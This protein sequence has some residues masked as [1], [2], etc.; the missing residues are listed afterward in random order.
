MC[1][2]R[3]YSKP[4]SYDVEIFYTAYDLEVEFEK[5]KVRSFLE[6]KVVQDGGGQKDIVD[7][8]N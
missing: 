2:S 4:S 8:L 3:E 1:K 6:D 5:N 7:K